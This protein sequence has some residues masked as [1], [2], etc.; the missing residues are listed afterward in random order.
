MAVLLGFAHSQLLD[1][2]YGKVFA[3]R[4]VDFRRAYQIVF[5]GVQVAVVFH[6]T[7]IHYIGPY[8]PVE[9]GEFVLFK[10]RSDFQRTVAAEVV[11]DHRIVVFHGTHRSFA[12]FGDDKSIQILVDG[13][14]GFTQ[15]GNCFV[16][17]SKHLAFAVNM[18]F[19]T[20][21]H[22]C[23]VGVVAVHGDLHTAAAGSDF[24]IA[25]RC[26]DLCKELFKG[27]DVIQCRSFRHITAV[28]QS[29]DAD[30]FH[31]F[32]SGLFDHGFQVVD[33]AVHIAVAEQ[34]QKMQCGVVVQNIGND[35]FP[36]FAFK[37]FAAFHCFGNQFGTLRKYSAAADGVVTD[38]AVAHII[39]GGHTNRSTVSFQSGI[40]ARCQKFIQNR[41]AG[42]L[43]RVA[44]TVFTNTH[45]VS[46]TKY[47]RTAAALP[48]RI[49]F[50]SFQHN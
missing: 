45:T 21:F 39:I 42:G 36:G 22:H 25:A 18:D 37:E 49:L 5:G 2:A 48:R 8:P 12:I 20:G 44:I 6:H 27:V 50:K 33:I 29:V 11:E 32:S 15:F 28:Q 17:G 9:I 38:F 24:G 47:H 10:R 16:G 1:F 19:P 7:G 31:P 13:T 40:G 46:N 35:L 23:P 4:A 34:A 30:D 14:G 41:S 3:Q 43:D 26:P